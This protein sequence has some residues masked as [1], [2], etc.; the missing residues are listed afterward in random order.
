MATELQVRAATLGDAAPI[1]ALS[2]ELGYPVEPPV[3]RQRLGRILAR[4]DQRL[5]VA[6]LP[7]GA[8]CGWLQAHA[9]DSVETGSRVEIVG[10]VVAPRQRRSGVGRALIARAEAWAAELSAEAIVVRSNATRVES[11]AFYPAL[12]Y[13]TWKTQVVYR[14]RPG[15]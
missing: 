1:G 9:C 15:A 7:G 13:E 14:K 2:A 6:E 12:G 4:D 5:L 11:H 3:L 8:V 10:L